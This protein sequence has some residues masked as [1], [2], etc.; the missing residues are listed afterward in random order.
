MQ[1]IDFS[2]CKHSIKN[3]FYGGLAGRKEGIVYNNENWLIKY[4]KSTKDMINVP[5]S[6]TTSPLNEYVGSHIYEILG[7][8][9][10]KTCL[11]IRQ[12]KLVVACKD[13][14]INDYKLFEIRTLKNYANEELGEKLDRFFNGTGSKHFVNF[15]ELYLHIK[16]NEIL[17]SIPGIEE[18]FWDMSIVDIFIRNSDRNDG[19]WGI[20]RNN[21][22]HNKLA[23]IFDNGGCFTDKADEEKLKTI[24]SDDKI[25]TSSLNFRCSYGREFEENNPKSLKQMNAKDFIEFSMEYEKFR[26]SLIKNIPII[27][28][29]L[30]EIN[31]MI[32][33]I[34]TTFN[35]IKICS[36]L[37]KEYFI[38]T[39]KIRL[40]KMLIPAYEKAIQF[41]NI[42][43]SIIEKENVENF[44]FE[45]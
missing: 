16:N 34:P 39:L 35:N 23:P 45:R 25:E 26:N 8:D 2:N 3:G 33:E 12:N 1:I 27:K 19:N 14:E 24:L 20:L 42:H 30:F 44:D 13:F 17:T 18:R 32:N 28:S 36:D 37:Q 29:K 5:I 7:Y 10:H 38:K 43:S 15:N 41:N 6:Y 31:N 9:V 4:P 40:N 21:N 11:G 22:N